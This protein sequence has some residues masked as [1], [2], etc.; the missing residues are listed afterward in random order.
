MQDQLMILLVSFLSVIA[1]AALV[2]YSCKECHVRSWVYLPIGIA[3]QFSFMAIASALLYKVLTFGWLKFAIV[4]GASTLAVAL[5]LPR[6]LDG[7]PKRWHKVYDTRT[8][9][10]LFALSVAAQV[11]NFIILGSQDFLGENGP[12]FRPP[13]NSD[14][15]RNTILVNSLLRED[16]SPFLPGAEHSY[17]MLWYHLA[18][19]FVSLFD[20]RGTYH[21]VA[22]STLFTGVL[23]FFALF[24][25][26]YNLKPVPF[27]RSRWL[28][29]LAMVI[30]AAHA[31]IYNLVKSYRTEG[32]LGFAADG[33]FVGTELLGFTLKATTLTSPQHTF[34]VYLLLAYLAGIRW[35]RESGDKKGVFHWMFLPLIFMTS[36]VLSLLM[37]P[38][39]FLWGFAGPSG[40]GGGTCGARLGCTSPRH[41]Q[42]GRD[43]HRFRAGLLR[44]AARFTTGRRIQIC[45]QLFVV[46]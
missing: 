5:L 16:G 20:A 15:Q 21:L 2:A 30:F 22:G 26:C 8:L 6:M 12:Y 10:V 39:F 40:G 3:L 7:E 31:D 38:F 1:P 24:W 18:A 11:D 34:F 23:V 42:S 37:L 25:L 29:P 28:L 36:P 35:L 41:L 32:V 9:L 13:L 45:Q 33:S 14:N 27:L 44:G 4:T 46:G 43:T 19:L 17:Q